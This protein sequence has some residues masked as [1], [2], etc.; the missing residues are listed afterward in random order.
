MPEPNLL[1]YFLA[2]NCGAAPAYDLTNVDVRLKG[3]YDY[4]AAGVVY[5]VACQRCHNLY[6]VETGLRLTDRFGKHLHSVVGYNQKPLPQGG[7]F[8]VDE[9][10]NFLD[11]NKIQDMR[12]F[13]VR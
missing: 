13:V 5:V 2:R 3:R 7:G 1:E 8:S 4:T 10:F 6:V 12:V 9:H 11:K